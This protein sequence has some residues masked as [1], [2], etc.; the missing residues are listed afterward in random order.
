VT[1]VS[2]TLIGLGALALLAWPF[3]A[4]AGVLITEKRTTSTDGPAQT[5]QV[6]IDRDWMRIEYQMGVDKQAIIFDASKS[7]AWTVNYDKRTYTEITKA[8]LERMNAQSA[9]A[10]VKAQEA[11][12]TMSPQQRAM[13]EAM[14]KAQQGS[15]QRPVYRKVGTDQV[16]RWTCDKYEGYLNDQKTSEVCTVAPTAVGLAEADF[17][18]TR[19]VG[20]FVKRLVPRSGDSLMSFGKTE[21][22]GFSGVPVRRVVS[23]GRRQLTTEVT[24]I[25]RQTFPPS[26][27][28]IPAGFTK[29]T[30]GQPMPM[31]GSP[32]SP[33]SQG[34]QHKH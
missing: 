23:L 27:W 2:R 1:I 10:M 22:Q 3:E 5:H 29:Q 11:M 6:Q 17:E 4:P 30:Y 8:D 32:G 15:T 18:V 26:T 13:M 12:K 33:G 21:E 25:S 24:D 28:E 31:S 7:V 16:G 34:G 9:E 20:E 14:L 19:K